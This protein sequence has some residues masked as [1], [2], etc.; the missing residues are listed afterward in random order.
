MSRAVP[1][2]HPG[3]PATHQHR[4]PRTAMQ[5]APFFE[6]LGMIVDVGEPRW[7]DIIAGL[8][9]LRLIDRWADR[10][11]KELSRPAV[12]AV[13]QAVNAI[14]D[15]STIR[16][17]LQEIVDAVR[18]TIGKGPGPQARANVLG[19]VLTYAHALRLGADWA[20]AAGAYRTVIVA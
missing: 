12:H 5:H 2:P 10:D 9:T 18:S 16:G 11:P 3:P 15:H 4:T 19:Q 8:V 14:D 6:A 20:L 17:S 13:A 1:L 7:R